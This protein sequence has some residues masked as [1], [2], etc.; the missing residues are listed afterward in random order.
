MAEECSV[1]MWQPG[2]SIELRDGEG[3]D[4][5]KRLEVVEVGYQDTHSKSSMC[6]DANSAGV[7]KEAALAHVGQDAELG[8]IARVPPVVSS[9]LF[10]SENVTVISFSQIYCPMD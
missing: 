2:A 7:S 4:P 1:K 3:V 5:V 6:M 8:V 9:Q 10:W